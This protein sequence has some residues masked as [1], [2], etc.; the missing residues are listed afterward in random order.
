M[1]RNTELHIM[2]DPASEVAELRALVRRQD[3]RI[4]RLCKKIRRLERVLLDQATALDLH[5]E[6]LLLLIQ[7][8]SASAPA[9]PVVGA[10]WF[11]SNSAASRAMRVG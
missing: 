9:A 3:E 2:D 11:D 10:E 4:T 5:S 6:A 8:G 7:Q 1:R